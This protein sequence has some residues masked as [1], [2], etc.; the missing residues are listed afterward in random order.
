MIFYRKSFKEAEAAYLKY[1]KAEK[2]MEISRLDLEKAKNNAQVLFIKL[3]QNC[4]FR[5]EATCVSRQ[6]KGILLHL[7]LRMRLK[8]CITLRFYP[9]F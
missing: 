2:N 1:Y 4:N 3:S 9:K 5:R 8:G 7:K 6:N